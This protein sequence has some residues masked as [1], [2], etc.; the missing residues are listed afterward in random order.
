MSR[1]KPNVILEHLN[2]PQKEQII[3]C[4]GIWAVLYQGQPINYRS[5]ANF[6]MPKYRK[7]AFSNPG[8]ANN[9]ARKLNR[10][11][12]TND[13]TVALLTTGI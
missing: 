2:G 10:K 3:A 7:T 4:E 9:L 11:F 5:V 13:F 8:H 6:Q 1:P 12:N